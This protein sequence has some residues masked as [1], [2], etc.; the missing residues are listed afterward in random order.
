MKKTIQQAASDTPLELPL[1]CKS[2]MENMERAL[3]K[4]DQETARNVAEERGTQP[5]RQGRAKNQGTSWG[6]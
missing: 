1:S 6:K 5:L 4:E 3:A 2:A